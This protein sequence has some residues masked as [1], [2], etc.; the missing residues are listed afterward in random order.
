MRP[1][2]QAAIT[3]SA[4]DLPCMMAINSSVRRGSGRIRAMEMIAS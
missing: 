3:L 1:K 4:G 2:A